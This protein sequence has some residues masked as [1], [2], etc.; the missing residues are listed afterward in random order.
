MTIHHYL[1][2]SFIV[3]F[4][5]TALFCIYFIIK[6]HQNKK[7]PKLLTE[8]KY[9]S[10]MLGKMTEVTVSD[11]S[12]FN[13]WPYISKLKTAKVLSHK[14]KESQLVHKI[15]RN[16]TEDF[17]HILLST[18]KE[19]HFVV[20]VANRNKKKTIGYFLQDDQN[21]LYA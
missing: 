11:Q 12:I 5:I 20:I 1:R 17:E 4:V 19:N 8:E 16:S 13:I 14:I 10:T 2:L 9:N 21:G 6:K 3:I 18:E 7:G 15:Y